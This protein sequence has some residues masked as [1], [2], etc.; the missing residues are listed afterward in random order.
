MSKKAIRALV[1]EAGKDPR[2]AA[3]KDPDG[4]RE[5][6]ALVGCETID[7]VTR[8]IGG[9]AYCLTV[10]D[11]GLLKRGLPCSGVCGFGERLVGRI[12]VAG[13]PDRD[14]SLTGLSDDDVRRIAKCVIGGVLCYDL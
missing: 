6:I 12:V 4:C 13:R 5:L 2:E 7:I 1:I 10:D 8:H 11:D 14:G 9:K 3:I